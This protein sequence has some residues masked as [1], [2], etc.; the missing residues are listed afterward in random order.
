ME[1]KNDKKNKSEKLWTSVGFAAGAFNALSPSVSPMPSNSLYYNANASTT[2]AKQSKASG[3]AYSIGVNVGT[4][5]SERWILQG[6]VNYLTQSSNYTANSVVVDNNFQSPQAE[7]INVYKSQV[8]LTMDASSA[9]V[10]P[11]VPYTVNNN[12]QFV[13]LPVQAGYLFVNR[14]FGLQL[15]A[16][17]STDLFLQNTISPE[18]GGI[19]STT[20]SRGEDSPYRSLNFSGLMG[21]EFSYKLGSRYR[22]ALNPGLRY[23]FNSLYKTNTGVESTP[24]TFDVGLR[25]RYIFQ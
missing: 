9:K 4:K 25:F 5:L 24:L 12:V 13:S 19:S 15:N 3:L 6:G 11:T 23:P 17:V 10:A 22:V 1:D 14:K 21:T 8:Q 18:G 20:Q 2:A 7:S 16:G